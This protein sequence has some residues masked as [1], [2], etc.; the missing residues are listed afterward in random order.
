MHASFSAFQRSLTPSPLL[1]PGLKMME[2]AHEGRCHNSHDTPWKSRCACPH[3]FPRFLGI[4]FNMHVAALRRAADVQVYC[5][6]VPQTPNLL[7]PPVLRL[8]RHRRLQG[9][10]ADPHKADNDLTPVE[11]AG[12]RPCALPNFMVPHLSTR[13]Q[14]PFLIFIR[15]PF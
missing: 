1:R 14:S 3:P 6:A 8:L 5:V 2:A 10:G 13:D 9:G 15:N 7:P 12:R 4:I 11:T